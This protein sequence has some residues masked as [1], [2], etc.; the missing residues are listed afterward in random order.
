MGRR[1]RG[2]RDSQAVWSECCGGGRPLAHAGARGLTHDM[3]PLAEVRLDQLLG[4]LLQQGL[5]MGWAGGCE[6]ERSDDGRPARA[7]RRQGSGQRRT[8]P[9]PRCGQP[10]AGHEGLGGPFGKALT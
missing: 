9:F 10:L 7:R 4:A 3:A 2:G 5:E 6:F 1:Q 8:R